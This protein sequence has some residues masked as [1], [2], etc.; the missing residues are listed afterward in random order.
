MFRICHAID[1]RHGEDARSCLGV[2]AFEGLRNFVRSHLWPFWLICPP[3]A[4]RCPGWGLVSTGT[5]P[6]ASPQFVAAYRSSLRCPF[7]VNS[8]PKGGWCIFG[9]P[10]LPVTR[11]SLAAVRCVPLV[12]V[13]CPGVGWYL[14]VPIRALPSQFVAGASA[15]CARRGQFAALRRFGIGSVPLSVTALQFVACR[16]AVCPSNSLLKDHTR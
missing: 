4:I 1:Q 7:G 12:S 9:C 16:A 2:R 5:C 8:L 15:C 14:R 10:P 6:L 3:G 13:R 11:V